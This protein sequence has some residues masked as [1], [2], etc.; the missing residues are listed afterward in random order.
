MH[1]LTYV[2]LSN[3]FVFLYFDS[4]N[5]FACK[6]S[7]V[8]ILWRHLVVIGNLIKTRWTIKRLFWILTVSFNP[9]LIV[10][11]FDWIEKG[12]SILCLL[13]SFFC[14]LCHLFVLI[15]I[16]IILIIFKRMIKNRI[17]HQLIYVLLNDIVGIGYYLFVEKTPLNFNSFFC[18]FVKL[19]LIH[20]YYKSD[21]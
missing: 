21:M 15:F 20:L 19:F 8:L 10:V 1:C 7:I 17:L 4:K 11:V 3:Y 6:A 12:F 5:L 2:R 16:L 9:L 14:F 18:P 13:L